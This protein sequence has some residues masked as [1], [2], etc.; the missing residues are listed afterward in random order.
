[1]N[2]IDSAVVTHPDSSPLE[3]NKR[4]DHWRPDITSIVRARKEAL[5]RFQ[6]P[7]GLMIP[8]GGER[9]S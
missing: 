4:G 5:R 1:M 3:K 7:A 6:S 2:H 8:A 9:A